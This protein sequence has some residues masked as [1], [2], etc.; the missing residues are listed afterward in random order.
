MLPGFIIDQIR[1][2]EEEEQ[3]KRP[4]AQVELHLPVPEGSQLPEHDEESDRGV[5]IIDLLPE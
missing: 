2:R 5:V 1:Q 3:A 4:V